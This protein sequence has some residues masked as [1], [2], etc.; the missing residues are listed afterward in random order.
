MIIPVSK[1]YSGNQ[2]AAKALTRV[3]LA[4]MDKTERLMEFQGLQQW[5]RIIDFAPGIIIT[6][7]K[8]FGQR[9]IHIDVA[10]VGGGEEEIKYICLCN[11]NF[12]FGI[13]L[14]EQ[15]EVLENDGSKL[16]T[17]LVCRN[18]KGYVI[19]KDLIATDF[20]PYLP[21]QK[22]LLIPYNEAMYQCCENLSS[23]TG[24]SPIKSEIAIAED[25]WRT[26]MRIIAWRAFDLK[27]WIQV[28]G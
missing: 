13:I 7:S 28:R 16:Y 23:S 12:A 8:C 24:C 11:C 19:E 25:N 20:S 1:S 9:S 17:V 15:V 3:A 22:V 14:E 18:K 27:K 10:S 5:S 21:G 2:V 4:E 6:T 26:I